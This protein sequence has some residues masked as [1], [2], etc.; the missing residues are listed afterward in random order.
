MILALAATEIE[1]QPFLRRCAAR[2]LP[3]RALV[4]G[5]G[6]LE[7]AV[8]VAA[9]LGQAGGRVRVAIDFGVAGAYVQPAGVPQ[10]Q[11]LDLCL[12]AAEVFGDFGLHSPDG[13]EPL[14]PSLAG[15]PC[16]LFDEPLLEVGRGVLARLG[17]PFFVGTFVTVA[18]A[19]TT[20]QRGM[21]LQRRWAGLCENMEGAAVLRACRQF[22]VP[23]VEVRA[24]SNLVEDR[25]PQR[26][27]LGEACE[28]AAEGAAS[29]LQ[30]VL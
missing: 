21:A 30:G 27:R 24:V 11:L 13:A 6:P 15:D 22:A 12:A 19:S 8:R 2:R 9:F 20:L 7:S 1:M 10:P 23:V 26:W 16:Q 4:T 3:C 18:A 25:C 29:V 17:R 28:M 5:V 14:P